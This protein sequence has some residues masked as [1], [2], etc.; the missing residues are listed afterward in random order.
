ML[1][2]LKHAVDWIWLFRAFLWLALIQTQ[3]SGC[4]S[5][6][7][8]LTYAVLADSVYRYSVSL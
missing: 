5:I 7:A 2:T 4:G 3:L 8:I 1:E 6:V